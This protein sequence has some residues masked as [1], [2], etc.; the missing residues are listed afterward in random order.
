MAT[1]IPTTNP[2]IPRLT[3]EGDCFLVEIQAALRG[4]KVVAESIKNRHDHSDGLVDTI[5]A[6]SEDAEDSLGN[7]R[8]L[9][10][11]GTA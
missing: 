11:N 3:N 8:K 9:L 7:L 5:W 2:T 6:I 4:I 1:D 10:E